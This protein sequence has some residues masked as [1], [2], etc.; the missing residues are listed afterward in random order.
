MGD[1]G[2]AMDT[3]RS[4]LLLRVQDRADSV[5]WGEFDRIY[6]PLLFKYARGR[7]LDE[8]AAED[9]VQHCMSGVVRYIEQF[10]YDPTKGRFKGWLRTLV[11]N[12]VRNMHRDRRDQP[13][14]SQDFKHE[15]QS[16]PAPDDIFDQLWLREHLKHCL[17]LIR[18]EVNESTFKA[19]RLYVMD[20]W[21]VEKVSAELDMTVNQVHKI[22]SRLTKKLEE[23][24]RELLGDEF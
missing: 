19:F 7:G 24:M 3:T 8:S 9:V 16:P 14:E 10:D 6:R 2:V 21:P 15:S 13:A 23:K 20:E 17:A 4:T 1:S 11:N 5:A 22:K 12:R 18:P